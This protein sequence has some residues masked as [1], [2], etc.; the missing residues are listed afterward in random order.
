MLAA[1]GGVDSSSTPPQHDMS[2]GAEPMPD[3]K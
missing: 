3:Y 2:A 1:D